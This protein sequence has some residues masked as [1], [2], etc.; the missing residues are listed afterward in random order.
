MRVNAY[1]LGVDYAGASRW[2]IALAVV[3]FLTLIAAPAFAFDGSSADGP[4]KISPKSFTSAEQALRAGIDDLNAGNAASSVAALTYAA[5]SGEPIARWKL[6][7]MYADGVGVPR[8]DVKAYHYFNQLVEEYDEDA[9]DQR[10]RSAISNAFVAVGVY[11]LNGIPN[12]QVR[13]DPV[14]ARELFLYAA[15]TF[16]DPDAQYNLAHMYLVGAGGLTRDNITAVRWLGLAAGKGHRPSQALLGHMLF[17]GD[18]IPAQ[19]A[20]GLMWLQI[21][22][23]GAEGAKEEWIRQLHD[24]D[25]GAAAVDDRQAA[26]AM[27]DAQAKGPPLPSFISRSVVKTMQILRPL[28]IPMLA[29]SPTPAE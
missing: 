15:T 5:E 7:E 14:R 17:I 26:A 21:A 13:A 24:R 22:K 23:K 20:R 10:N 3:G 28:N 4:A 18:G 2:G 25:F 19:R 12:S 9:P 29:A 27:L 16:G 1:E 11:C 8:D 6:G